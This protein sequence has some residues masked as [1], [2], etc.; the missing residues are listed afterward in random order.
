M[1]IKFGFLSVYRH[2]DRNILLQISKS[3]L[4]YELQEELRGEFITLASKFR[5][6]SLYDQM[7]D[8]NGDF[9]S[10]EYELGGELLHELGG[11]PIWYST[12]DKN[13][14][15]YSVMVPSGQINQSSQAFQFLRELQAEVKKLYPKIMT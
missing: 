8:I 10:E 12:C 5:K 6:S 14:L 11:K 4:S 13:L 15:V 3:C 7:R 1:S 9:S 2:S